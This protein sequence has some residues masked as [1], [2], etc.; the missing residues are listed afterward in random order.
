M[1]MTYQQALEYLFSF[2]PSVIRLGL[3]KIRAILREF[4]NPQDQY[5]SIL[6]AGTNGKGS[7]TAMIS[8]ILQREGLKV[9]SYTSPHLLDFRE[10]ISINGDLIPESEVVKLTE[11]F[12]R[13]LFRQKS[14][15]SEERGSAITGSELTFFEVGTILAFLH[16]T[17]QNIDIAVLEVGL[18]GRLDAT[19][20]VN[21][22]V[23]V[24]TNISFDHQDYLGSTLPEIAREKAGIIK[25]NGIALTACEPGE[26]LQEIQIICK[27][28]NAQLFEMG[29]H[30]MVSPI[31]SNLTGQTFSYRGIKRN[32]EQ[33]E[34][35]LLG[36]HQILNASLAVGTIELLE[37]FGFWV[38]E[39]NLREGLKSATNPG[40]LEI[41]RYSPTVVLDAAHNPGGAE[42]LSKALME[43][44]TYDRLILIVGILKDK[45]IRG[46]FKALFSVA[47]SVIFTQPQNTERATPAEELARVA[48]EMAFHKYS[49]V[50]Q[51][52]KA[53]ELAHKFAIPA[54]L[55]CVTGSLYTIA[56]AKQFYGRSFTF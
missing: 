52:P 38:Q 32:Y 6:I 22:L 5:P 46:M 1:N 44:F 10:R 9:G 7:T 36:K 17:Q 4:D 34:I 33:L 56:E 21:P 41:I 51:V 28:K 50:P 16:F 27:Q 8:S 42:V 29:V 2:K 30:F 43:L 55:I 48:Q 23:S 54:D 20:V 14:I 40:R 19:N 12:S 49:V 31:K 3:D 15:L 37:P 11:E 53:I 47:S 45:D 18:G 24:I 39:S 35:S 26:A 13:I 25:E